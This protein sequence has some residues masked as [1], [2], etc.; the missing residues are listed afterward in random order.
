[1]PAR[2]NEVVGPVEA[3]AAA[4]SDD[5]KP[6]GPQHAPEEH[7]LLEAIAAAAAPDELLLK[8]GGIQP[9][10]FAGERRETFEWNRLRVQEME[11]LQ[12]FERR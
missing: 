5:G 9:H 4:Q 7:V 1:M 3:H 2:R 8:R 12:C 11:L 6:D 10:F